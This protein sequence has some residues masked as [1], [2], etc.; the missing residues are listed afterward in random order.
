MKTRQIERID[1]TLFLFKKNI[2]V[3]RFESKMSVYMDL[4]IIA[5]SDKKKLQN[6]IETAAHRKSA[7]LISLI[8][9]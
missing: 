7:Y 3:E 6:I 5:V 8:A 2:Y 1:L 4:N 9:E